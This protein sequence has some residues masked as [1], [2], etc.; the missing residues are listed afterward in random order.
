M[1]FCGNR[2]GSEN[3]PQNRSGPALVLAATEAFGGISS[4]DS[5]VM[6]TLTPVALVKASISATKASSSLCTKYFQRSIDSCALGSGFHG[7]ACAQALAQSSKAGP[8][9]APVAPSAVPPFTKARRVSMVMIVP[10]FSYDSL[11]RVQSL[12]G[13]LVEQVH[14]PWIG[15]EPDRV[16]RLEGVPLAEHGDHVLA[17]ELGDNL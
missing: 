6:L 3:R 11:L 13:R 17:A 5:R 16:A 7:A 10:P 4:Y 9:S 1:H 8:V 14:E 15:F 2:C 12:S